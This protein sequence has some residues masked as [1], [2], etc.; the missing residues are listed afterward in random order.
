MIRQALCATVRIAPGRQH[1][2]ILEL[3]R[4]G[5]SHSKTTTATAIALR[6]TSHGP[7]DTRIRHVEVE[8]TF[9][10]APRTHYR[11]PVPISVTRHNSSPF[12]VSLE[13]GER[14]RSPLSLNGVS[15][16]GFDLEAHTAGTTDDRPCVDARC[17]RPN[18]APTVRAHKLDA[19][20]AA[21]RA[22]LRPRPYGL[23]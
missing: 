3:W 20:T 5:D 17:R 16:R 15:T 11:G 9:Y 7:N 22:P 19:A 2:P 6:Q 14:Q 4:P 23:P 13:R 8:Q 21:F 18:D 12:N 1:A 10:S